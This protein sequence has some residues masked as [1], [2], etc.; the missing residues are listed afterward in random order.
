[1]HPRIVFIAALLVWYCP[2]EA[3]DFSGE[4]FS[5]RLPAAFSEFSTYADVAAKGGASAASK[6]GSSINPAAM[7][8]YFPG[9]YDYGL[10]AQYSNLAFQEGTHLDFLS[11]SATLDAHALGTIRF[12][13]GQVTSNDRAIRDSPLIFTYDLTAGRVDWAKRWGAWSVGANFTYGESDTSFRTAKLVFADAERHTSTGRLGVLWEPAPHWLGG[14]VGEYATAPTRTDLLTPTRFGLA[15]SETRDTGR[16]AVLR[17]GLAYEWREN[18]LVH[19][20]YQFGRFWNETGSLD[21]NRVAAGADL[22]LARFF[23]VRAGALLDAHG[24][25]GWT[26]GFGIYP[27]KGIT[28]DFAFQNDAFPE[29]Q[30][31]FGHSR[32]LNASMSWQF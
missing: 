9:A 30:R 11:E 23:F 3:N 18:A 1:M 32:T 15:G 5:L 31:E 17:A 26:A 19:L 29:L 4:D 24:D 12:S 20:D 7:A 25:F 27:R 2:L 14:L 28:L 21:S 6:F 22:P 8:W 10:S 16:Q 13:F